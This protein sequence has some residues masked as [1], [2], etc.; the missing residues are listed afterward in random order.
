MLT[1]Y[2]PHSKQREI[3]NAINNGNHKYYVVSIGRQFGKTQLAEWM[4]DVLQLEKQAN[5]IDLDFGESVVS[6]G[7]KT[8]NNSFRATATKNPGSADKV[9]VA[10]FWRC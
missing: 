7:N 4:Q 3:H 6:Q 10:G 1:L 9:H 2:K 5:S 8:T